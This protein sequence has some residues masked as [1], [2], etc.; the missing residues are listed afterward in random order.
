MNMTLNGHWIGLFV[1]ERSWFMI[2]K[3][4]CRWTEHLVTTHVLRYQQKYAYFSNRPS[5]ILSLFDISLV[6]FHQS[7][8]AEHRTKSLVNPWSPS[9]RGGERRETDWTSSTSCLSWASWLWADS[10]YNQCD[11]LIVRNDYLLSEVCLGRV[12]SSFWSQHHVH[13]MTSSI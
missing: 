4:V 5:T 9:P 12:S 7:T 8:K 2:T 6:F 1:F 3:I 13:S 11:D 10:G